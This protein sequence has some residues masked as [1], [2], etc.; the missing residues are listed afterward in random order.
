MLPA[1]RLNTP[2]CLQNSATLPVSIISTNQEQVHLIDITIVCACIYNAFC[3]AHNWNV[4]PWCKTKKICSHF[5]TKPQCNWLCQKSKLEIALMESPHENICGCAS[6]RR[7]TE[8]SSTL[9]PVR[10]QLGCGT[11]S[12]HIYQWHRHAWARTIVFSSAPT[13]AHSS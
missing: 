8:T 5:M 9:Q 11:S 3:T 4:L 2:W 13:D 6:V 10:K 12:F 7:R 1:I